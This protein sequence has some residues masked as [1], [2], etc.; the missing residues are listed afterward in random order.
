MI[1]DS[2]VEKELAMHSLDV[3]PY[4]KLLGAI[5][6]LGVSNPDYYRDDCGRY[7]AEL[8]GLHPSALW[9]KAVEG[10]PYGAGG[11][12][13]LGSCQEWAHAEFRTL[14]GWVAARGLEEV[15]GGGGE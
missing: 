3:A 13:P 12:L 1:L 14:E 11:Y 9:H 5:L 7:W 4:L 8:V 15:G 2:R 6:A 10:T